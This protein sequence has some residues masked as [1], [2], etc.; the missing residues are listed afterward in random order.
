MSEFEKQCQSCGMPLESGKQSGKEVNGELSK[1]YCHYCYANGSFIQPD[2]TLEEMKIQVD[3]ALK[4]KG[5]IKPLRWL[6]KIQLPKLA[7]WRS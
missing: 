6:A 5:W 4:E 1:M 2:I 3:A 7:R